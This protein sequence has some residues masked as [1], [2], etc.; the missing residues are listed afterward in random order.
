MEQQNAPISLLVCGDGHCLDGL[1]IVLLSATRNTKRPLHVFLMTGSFKTK[2]KEYHAFTPE[3]VVFAEKVLQEHSPLSTLTCIDETKELDDCFA[4]SW[5]Y[6]TKFSP[7]TLMRLFIDRHPELGDRVVYLDLDIVVT[8]DLDRLDS[9]DL[10]GASLG[11]VRDEV[12]SHCLGKNYCN[13]GVL[14]L[15]AKKIR[16]NHGFE[17]VR[18][19]LL[20]H[21]YFMPDQTA[22][23]RVFKGDIAFLSPRFNDQHYLH[24][25]TV[26][27]HYCK[28]YR[29]KSFFRNATA[30][31]WDQARFE[32]NYGPETHKEILDE[33]RAKKAEFLKAN[34]AK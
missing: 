27:R 7:Y 14:L 6:D 34:A 11:M 5:V 26:I 2:Q 21:H 24:P 4:S 10:H 17:K 15:D 3:Q 33:Y 29:A 23:N 20:H 30:K 18:K 22:I 13:A 32:K 19:H 25:D 28:W 12:G 8:G 16:E 1:L 9:T 31:P